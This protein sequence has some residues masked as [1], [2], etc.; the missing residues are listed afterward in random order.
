MKNGVVKNITHTHSDRQLKDNEHTREK[1][2]G[3]AAFKSTSQKKP[4]VCV[5]I[6][7]LFLPVSKHLNQA[8]QIHVVIG[9][10]N[11]LNDP[12]HGVY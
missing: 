8:E 2:R 10:M 4:R 9:W 1:E 6:Y 11:G 3:G 7:L 5:N 12:D